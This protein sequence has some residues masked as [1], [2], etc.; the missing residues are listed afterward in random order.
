[1]FPDVVARWSS[2]GAEQTIKHH[3]LAELPVAAAPACLAACAMWAPASV[4]G[5]GIDLGKGGWPQGVDVKKSQNN[6]H[7]E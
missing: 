6:A 5:L 7:N 4:L 3:G 2:R 1:M